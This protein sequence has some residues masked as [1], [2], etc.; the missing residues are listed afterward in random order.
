MLDSRYY[1]MHNN[2]N[3]LVLPGRCWLQNWIL[4]HIY[5]NVFRFFSHSVVKRAN[6]TP[7]TFVNPN[8][9]THGYQKMQKLMLISNP[10]KKVT[11]KL[12]RNFFFTK[13]YRGYGVFYFALLLLILALLL[14]LKPKSD[15]G[16][17]HFVKKIILAGLHAALYITVRSYRCR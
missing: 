17:I 1:S 2:F 10:L 7:K 8:C 13:S 16:R 9:N 12:T 4:R 5:K 11:K 15:E 6:M 3:I 14:I